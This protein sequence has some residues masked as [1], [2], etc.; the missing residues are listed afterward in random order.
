MS[1]QTPKITV[2]IPVFQ[3]QET[4]A[5][6]ISGV[7]EILTARKASFEIVAVDDGSNDHSL[8]CLQH[9]QERYGCLR[10]AHHQYNRGYGSALRTGIRLARGEIVV[11]MDAD[12]QH[13]PA[14]IPPLLDNIPP[15]DLVVGCRTENYRGPWHRNAGNRFYNIF[16]SWLAKTEIKDLTS[17]FRA[18]RRV[19]VSHFLPLYP[20][21][22]SASATTILAFLKAGYNVTFV[23]VHV[24]PRQN[25]ESKINF[26]KDG[27]RFLSV[28][29]RM[30]MLY[31][32]LRIFLPLAGIL[33]LLGLLAWGAGIQAAKRLIF[34]NSAVLLFVFTLMDILLGL[35]SSQV[36]STRIHYFGDETVTVYESTE[37]RQSN[38]TD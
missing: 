23:P 14:E 30:I 22:F 36:A 4:V 32:P 28:I 1:E 17:G 24:Q 29:L 10:V 9:L 5:H 16:S 38:V 33:F 6:T 19:A 21:G 12:G 11:C 26:F 31:D 37:G 20:S 18:M 27:W 34:P 35:L 15:Y 2:V 13:L 25:G 3:E 8:E 7:V